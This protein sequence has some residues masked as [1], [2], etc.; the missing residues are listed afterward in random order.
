MGRGLG[1]GYM[2]PLSSVNPLML[3][4]GGEHTEVFVILTAL[5]GLLATV[6]PHGE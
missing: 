1:H 3:H 6:C 4:Q 2:G 5:I